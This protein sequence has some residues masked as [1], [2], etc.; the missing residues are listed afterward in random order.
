MRIKNRGASAIEFALILPFL[1]LIVDATIEISILMFD[2]VMIT[3]AAREAVRAGVVMSDPKL[4]STEIA[5]IATGYCGNFLLSFGSTD[6]LQVS[7]V[8]AAEGAY[9][10]LLTVSVSYTY[11]SMLLGGS[12]AAFNSPVV[13]VSVATGLNE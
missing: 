1:L 8:Q 4:S 6:T 7:A 2:K 10:T 5:Q 11:T 3:N 13:L 9:K 12:L